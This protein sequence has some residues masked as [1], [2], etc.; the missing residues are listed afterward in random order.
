MILKDKHTKSQLSLRAHQ[1]D[2]QDRRY[3]PRWQVDTK[4]LI[5]KERD[6]LAYPCHSK[7]MNC[8]GVCVKT[9]KDFDIN[10]KLF[11]TIYLM[12]AGEPIQACGRTIWKVF[13]D[14]H[15]SLG[16]YF[17]RIA[18]SAQDLILNHAFEF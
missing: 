4:I 13:E 16:V 5:R 10:Q 12:Q 11:L 3:L 1:T 9:E 18:K 2:L 8:S 15:Y 6:F 7:D 17:E 14:S